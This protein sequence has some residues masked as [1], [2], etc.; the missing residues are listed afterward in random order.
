LLPATTW[1]EKEGTVTNSERRISRVRAALAPPGEARHDWQIATQFAHVLAQ[2]LDR[3]DGARLFPYTDAQSIFSEHVETTRGRDLDITG[4]SYAV[5]E[6]RGPQQWPFPAGAAIGATRLYAD[7]VF[8]TA[9][10][11]ARF[12]N[13]T[14]LPLAESPDASR[15]FRLNTGRLR[16][17]WHGMS[18]TG[19]AAQL[20][21]HAP[22]PALAMHPDAMRALACAPGDLVRVHNA[23][24]EVVLP[25]AEDSDVARDGAFV[26]MHWG[27]RFLR[28][29]GIN[30][31]TS[32]SFD[33]VSK[34]PELKHAAVQIEKVLLPWRVIAMAR[35]ANADTARAMLTP[36]FDAFGYAS[37]GLTGGGGGNSN[38]D[39]PAGDIVV[40]RAAATAPVA[41]EVLAAL[42]AALGI[43]QTAVRFHDRAQ[44]VS[45]S[46]CVSAQRL[47]TGFRLAGFG[48]SGD[49]ALTDTLQHHLESR[50]DPGVSGYQLLSPSADRARVRAPRSRIVCACHNVAETD[51]AQCLA[52]GNQLPQ[53]Q[54]KLKCGTGCGSCV[55]ELKR[56]ARAAGESAS[57][58]QTMQREEVAA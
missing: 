35:C 8:P 48:D 21:T 12:A 4:L 6:T 39:E 23:R 54:I 47:L 13:T 51:I 19:R 20:A 36:L 50:A 57:A 56:M 38:S 18:R 2:K 11:H 58:P 17:Q 52:A 24:G 14:F 43:N 25:V 42:D 32:P 26:P 53:V 55:P 22:E 33:P 49:V 1:G 28:G 40:F 31:L 41:D 37:C 46:V 5:L 34:Q 10:G 27:S 3:D 16:D 44:G 45:R 15:P 9:T 29:D 30:A 7:G